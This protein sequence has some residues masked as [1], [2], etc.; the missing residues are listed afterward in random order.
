[1]REAAV[2]AA[3][4]R[5]WKVSVYFEATDEEFD[6][7]HDK[8]LDAVTDALGCTDDPEHVCKHFRIGFGG[9]RN[10]GRRWALRCALNDVWE[11]LR[12]G[13]I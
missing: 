1:M 13:E 7:L 5:D 11:A 10:R 6:A 12:Y 2:N 9:P 3:R 4:P 8:V